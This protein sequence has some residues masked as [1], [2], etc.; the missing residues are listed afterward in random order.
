[1]LSLP[2]TIAPDD[3]EDAVTD[4]KCEFGLALRWMPE[5][6][7]DDDEEEGH[8]GEYLAPANLERRKTVSN[9]A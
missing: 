6:K 8:N 5:D 4:R 3:E 7:R 9:L 1:M 2:E